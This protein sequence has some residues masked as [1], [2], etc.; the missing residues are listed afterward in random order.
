[1]LHFFL[2][3]LLIFSSLYIVYGGIFLLN[4]QL[5]QNK[6]FLINSLII[7]I[8][9]FATTSYFFI[10][11]PL[12]NYFHNTLPNYPYAYQTLFIITEL[13]HFFGALVIAC[14]YLVYRKL[15]LHTSLY[16]IKTQAI[17]LLKALILSGIFVN[18]L[19][20]LYGRARPIELFNNN[21]YNFYPLHQ[22]F[23]IIKP[24]FVTS[25][26]D[27]SSHIVNNSYSFS[28]FPSG[29][30]ITAFVV[31][32]FLAFNFNS[33]KYKILFFSIGAIIALSRV[34]L[35]QHF[36]SD[37]LIGSLLGFGFAYYFFH[38]LMHKKVK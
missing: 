1:M 38:T 10:D 4:K 16:D 14:L 20:V 28:S 35:S 26:T 34:I 21:N 37:V 8:S 25:T 6:H 23:S 15:Y 7:F 13:G 27:I 11:A 17:A 29:H 32:S 9:S 31:F 36:F 19:K 24:L 2:V 22:A 18:I 30:S 5:L 33:L 12:A 3:C